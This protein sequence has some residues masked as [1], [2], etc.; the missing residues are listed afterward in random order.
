MVSLVLSSIQVVSTPMAESVTSTYNYTGGTQTFTVPSAVL[1]LSLSVR[2][3][4]GGV[5][6]TDGYT[7]GTAGT[8]VGVVSGTIAVTPGQVITIYVGSGGSNGSGCVANSGGGAGGLNPLTGYDG[9]TGGNAGGTGCS[10]GGGGGGAATVVSIAGNTVVAGG[11]GGSGGGN[12]IRSDNVQ[13]ARSGTTVTGTNGSAGGTST[14]DGGGGGGGGGGVLGGS[15]GA[16]VFIDGSAEFFGYGGFAGTSTAGGISGLSASTST[17]TAATDGS[18]TFTYTADTT[19]PTVANVTGLTADGFFTSGA[20]VYVT[21]TFSETVTVTGS[22]RL[23]L[24]TGATDRYATYDGTGSGTPTL[25]FLYTVQ[26]SDNSPDLDYVAT[27]SLELNSGTIKDL[28]GN[29]ASLT[30]QTPGASGSLAANKALVIDNTPP[31]YVSSRIPETGTTLILTYSETLST[32]TALPA[33]FTVRRAGSETI[34]VNSVTASGTNVTLTLGS[35]IF[36]GQSITVSYTDPTAGDDPSAIQDRALLEAATITNQSVTNNSTQ[37][38]TQTIAIASLGASSKAYPY[39]QAL[40]ITTSGSSG[41]GAKSYAVTNG[42]ATGCALS[43]STSA[44]AVLTATTS[45]TCN[46]TVT[47]AA[48]VTYQSATSASVPFTFAKASQTITF[49]ALANRTLGTGTFT[50]SATVSTGLALTFTSSPTSRCTVSGTTVTTITSGLCTITANQAGDDNYAQASSQRSFTISETL[51]ITTPLSGLSATNGVSYSLSIT[52]SGGSG[53][54]TFTLDSGS[55]PSGLSLS[56]SGNTATISGTPT[57]AGQSTVSVR[58]TDSNTA[59]AST[60]SFMI[61]VAK[62]SR[63]ISITS[64]GTSTKAFPYSQALNISTSVSAGTGAVTYSVSN[65]TAS[66]CALSDTT[67]ATAT[68]SATTSGSCLI[69]AIVATDSN[70]ESATSTAATFTFSKANQASIFISSDTTVAFGSTLALTTSG[71]SGGGSVSFAVSSGDCTIS[72]SSLTAT[73]VT[74]CIITATKAEDDNYLA[75]TSTATTI[76]ITTGSAT[77]TLSFSS[78]TFTFG[79]TNVITVTASTPGVVRFS[80]NGKVI[81]ACKA[82]ATTLTGSL[83]ATCSYRPDTRRPLTITAV[84]TPTDTRY[85]TRTSVSGTFLVARRV[86]R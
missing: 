78:L 21:I 33:H 72:G 20:S 31:T 77:A 74:S 29:N 7:G 32:A 13:N 49:P 8:F 71:G 65:D 26:S 6:G 48:D 42:T 17:Y 68:L 70:Y 38:T 54:N 23:L 15:G 69:R 3:G 14:G 39:S 41:S 36:G 61:T 47:I 64:L 25:R 53:G 10:G 80:A 5:G 44:T 35:T 86:G 45:G 73:A 22:P 50:V 63:T 67:S 79:I 19:A 62:A 46:V 12:N 76:T 81:K 24:E 58:V 4:A 59:T 37:R 56:G 55:L 1:S 2:G 9:G 85:A 52:S 84:L 82:R 30:L 83:T 16:A 27:N 75:E 43:D 57:A 11:G 28:A 18:V 66:G 51:T 34:T 60:S 40:S